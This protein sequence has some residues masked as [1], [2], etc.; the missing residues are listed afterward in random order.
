MKVELGEGVKLGKYLYFVVEFN[1]WPPYKVCKENDWYVDLHN[2]RE[3]VFRSHDEHWYT[4]NE[5]VFVTQKEATAK[6]KQLNNEKVNEYKDFLKENG[7]AN[8]Y[9]G[10]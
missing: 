6:K 8:D 1:S 4:L 9:K 2:W 5:D 3:P 7:L 10:E